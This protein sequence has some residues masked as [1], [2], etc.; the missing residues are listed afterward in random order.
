MTDQIKVAFIYDPNY[1][2]LNGTHFD[3]TTY[4]FFMHAL[5]RNKKINVTYFPA[6]EKFD[7]TQLNGK[8]DIILL[9]NNFHEGS[10]KI[11]DGIETT[12]IPVISRVGDPHDIKW[13]NKIPYHKKFKINY[14]FNFMD[15][16]YFYKFY[17]K[18]FKY[19][20]IVFGLEPSL[21]KNLKPYDKRIKNKILNSGAVGKTTLKSRIANRILNPQRSGWYFYK[22]RTMCN[23]L[24][25]VD[26]NGIVD[27]KYM[28]ENYIDMLSSYCASIAATTYY[29]TIKYWEI[30]ASGCLTFMEITE[31]NAGNY[32]GF[33]DGKTA[34]FID[35]FNYK[36]KFQEF[37]NSSDDPKWKKIAK[38]GQEFSLQNHSNDNAVN[39]LVNLMEE[40][41]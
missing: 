37:L 19:R 15:S 38:D 1:S 8:Y 40:I 7:V 27:G 35:E 2:F 33:I 23:S 34:I 22:L 32:L 24:S 21:Y 10:P 3:K 31:Q 5:K 16:T 28:F 25:Y 12:S 4:Y 13:K 14:Y 30:P 6:S 36:T 18:D 20:T 41:L 17:P 9:P 29:P 11:L 26:Y 39:N